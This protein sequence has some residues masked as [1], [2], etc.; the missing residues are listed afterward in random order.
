MLN[1]LRA[2]LR[3]FDRRWIRDP[4]ERASHDAVVQER[5]AGP[6]PDE[7]DDA[8]APEVPPADD[9]AEDEAARG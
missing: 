8:P 9:T 5:L 6:R 3:L 4:D 1:W 2:R 7:S